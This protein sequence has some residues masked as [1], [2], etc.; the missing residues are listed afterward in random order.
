MLTLKLLND[1]SKNWQIF[2]K[3][4]NHHKS[5]VCLLEEHKNFKSY[6]GKELRESISSVISTSICIISKIDLPENIPTVKVSYQGFSFPSLFSQS[7]FSPYTN[8]KQNIH[9]SSFYNGA[10]LQEYESPKRAK[11]REHW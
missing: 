11:Q 7:S 8:E 3:L 9:L 4:W 6:A 1:W 5:V 2:L 10:H